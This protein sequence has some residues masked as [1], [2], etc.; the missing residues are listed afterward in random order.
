MIEIWKCS[1]VITI[2]AKSCNSLQFVQ[3]QYKFSDPGNIIIQP[4]CKDCRILNELIIL[5]F[6][7]K[8]EAY[9]HQ[10][11]FFFQFFRCSD[12]R[13]FISRLE[14]YS[15][16]FFFGSF[17]SPHT[18][19]PISV[20]FFF[21]ISFVRRICPIKSVEYAWPAKKL[22]NTQTFFSTRF[23]FYQPVCFLSTE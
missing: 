9:F 18:I 17:I 10:R 23:S 1:I 4:I 16:V 22:R 5:L 3:L 11:V 20:T 19:R 6:T 15:F 7:A 21:Q 14:T 2:T 8:V 13:L 12:H